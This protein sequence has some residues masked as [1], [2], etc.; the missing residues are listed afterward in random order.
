MLAQ[1]LINFLA[2]YMNFSHSCKTLGSGI[3]YVFH[4]RLKRFAHE[5]ETAVKA[6]IDANE[7]FDRTSRGFSPDVIEE[8]IKA[9]LEPL[10]AQISALREMMDRLI[11]GKS[12]REF[13]TASTRELRLQS[14][15]SFAEASAPLG[16]HL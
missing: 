15:S 6:E 12:A 2:D 3:T 13:K 10:H 8:R 16:S 9:N 1:F 14:E 7:I 5:E 11:Q 4:A